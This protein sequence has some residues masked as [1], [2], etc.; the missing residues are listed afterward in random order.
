MGS[1]TIIRC[2]DS[3]LSRFR[4][5]DYYVPTVSVIFDNEDEDVEVTLEIENEVQ[6]LLDALDIKNNVELL[7]VFDSPSTTAYALCISFWCEEDQQIYSYNVPACY[8]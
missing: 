7:E 5:D 8:C 1:E 3:I 6:K 2:I 4:E